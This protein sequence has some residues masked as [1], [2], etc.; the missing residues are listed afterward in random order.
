MKVLFLTTHLNA[1]GIT[2][3]LYTLSKGLVARGDEVC[4]LSSGGNN[5]GQFTSM[6]VQHFSFDIKTKSELSPKLYFSLK[7]IVN[8]IKKHGIDILHAQTRVTQVMGTLLQRK[9]SLP[10]VSTC[11]GF[12]KPKLSRKMFPCW[13]DKVIAIS[14]AVKD[15]LIEDFSVCADE[16]AL[17]KN[18]IEL[19]NFPLVKEQ[20]RAEGRKQKDITGSLVVGIIARLSDVK[21]HEVLID[22]MAEVFREVPDATLIIV[23]EGKMEAALKERVAS[24][25]CEKQVRFFPTVNQTYEFLSLFDLFVMPSLQEGLG[26]SVMEA[27]AAGL[28]VIASKVGGLPSLIDDQK[29]GV[30]V[31]PQD[32][33]GLTQAILELSSQ[34]DKAKQMG[35]QARD[36][37]NQECSAGKMSEQTS[38]VYRAVSGKHT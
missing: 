10:Y 30:L 29:T 38:E 34:K 11:H 33:A 24:L 35:L 12:F 37:I 5:V 4:I 16:I 20:A 21:G 23:G 22:A 14:P 1:G 36:F 26:L 19:N 15:H 25:G 2:S 3:Y 17:V 27:Q 18:G 31:E 13:G 9:C 32:R 28:P 6:G 7:P 8:I